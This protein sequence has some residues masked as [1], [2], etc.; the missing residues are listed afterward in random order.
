[1]LTLSEKTKCSPELIYNTGVDT[2]LYGQT[3]GM[4]GKAE[5]YMVSVIRQL[6]SSG[7]ECCVWYE[8]GFRD[9]TS[10]QN[11]LSSSF[12]ELCV[13]SEYKRKVRPALF[14]MPLIR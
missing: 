4:S 11:V 8:N 13:W 5:E 9:E 1:M 10:H 7:V 6:K 12:E 2:F 3:N 14:I